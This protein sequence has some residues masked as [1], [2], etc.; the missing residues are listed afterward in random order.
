MRNSSIET[1]YVG[2]YSDGT[3][4]YD[5][6]KN[7]EINYFTPMKTGIPIPFPGS[8]TYRTSDGHALRLVG[9]DLVL[10]NGDVLTQ[11]EL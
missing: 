1:V 9:D 3:K 11:V 5:V 10:P 2:S 8:P 6:F 7:T 4:E